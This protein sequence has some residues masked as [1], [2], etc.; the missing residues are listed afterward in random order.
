MVEL[1]L[2]LLFS[3]MFFIASDRNW[4]HFKSRPEAEA[5]EVK[6]TKQKQL[7]I[8]YSSFVIQ[9]ILLKKSQKLIKFITTI[10]I[11]TITIIVVIE[12]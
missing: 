7:Q 9:L 6:H 12:M 5:A 11:I 10:T 4:R 8:G 2:L 1:L 3:H